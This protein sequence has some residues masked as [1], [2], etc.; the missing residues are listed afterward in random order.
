MKK[1]IVYNVDYFINKF[2]AIPE[3]LWCQGSLTDSGA[4]RQIG[5]TERI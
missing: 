1:E 5:K 2:E 4:Q 3:H